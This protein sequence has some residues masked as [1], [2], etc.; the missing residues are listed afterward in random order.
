MEK[1]HIKKEEQLRAITESIPGIVFQF[2]A[3]DTGEFGVSH[4]SGG[5]FGLFGLQAAGDDLF[6]AIASCAHED[7]RERFIASVRRSVET[8]TA[9][10]YEGRFVR[11]DGGVRWF[12]GRSAPTRLTDRVVFNGI[13][14]DVTENKLAEERS[15]QSEEK[16][17]KV[18]MMAPDPICITRMEDGQIVDVNLGFEEATG[19]KRN[20]VIGRTTLEIGLWA[21]AGDRLLIM[22]ELKARKHVS[23]RELQFRLKDGSLHTGVYSARFIHI[24]G[25]LHLISVI[26]DVTE[27][28][29]IAKALQESQERLQGIAMNIP[30]SVF[31]TYR[32]GN[33]ELGLSYMNESLRELLGIPPEKSGSLEDFLSYVHEDDRKRF[34]DSVGKALTTVTPWEFEGRFV[35]R[36]GEAVWLHGRAS[37]A[38]VE[39]RLVFN[40][41]FIDVTESKRAEQEQEKLREQ[42]SQAHKMES[43]GRL[44]GGVAHDFNNMLTV[45]LGHAEMAMMQCDPSDRLYASLK[46]IQGSALHSTSL[47]QQLLAFARKQT[48]TP[49]TLDLNDTVA[50]MVEMLR[51]LIGEDIDFV[52]KPGASLWPVKIDPSQ[53]DQLL[54]N[55]CVNSRDA[56]T[57]VGRI[58]VET[59]NT[60]FGDAS[61]NSHPGT[62]PGEYVMLAVSDNGCGM[63]KET[64]DQIFEPFFT[65]KETGKGTGLGLAT[66]YGIAQQNGGFVNVYS[67]PGRGSTFKAY[68]PRF[69]G[70]AATI[71]REATAE[72]PRGNGETVLLVEDVKVV[73]VLGR[74]M[75]ERLGY[76]VIAAAT[77]GE[78]IQAAKE[79]GTE[80]DLLIT[81]VIMPE[82]NGRDLANLLAGMIP[83]LKCLFVSGYT[84]DAITHQG[85]LEEGVSFLEKPFSVKSLAGK[86][87]EVLQQG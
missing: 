28:R 47:V 73:L 57:G 72:P 83:G 41:I 58:T 71:A 33:G 18:F 9:W 30:G 82:M 25:E 69:H 14:L 48:V 16:F 26:Q 27:H 1:S 46:A 75:L 79:R 6:S 76:T 66:V 54:T 20:E 15:R 43:I 7:D 36:T 60:T 3:L 80:I 44:A 11:L 2:Y 37:P 59:R 55:L 87:R 81:D 77:P 68:L 85:I 31:Q 8:C 35:T 5:P 10:D 70:E 65:T 52:W 51:R 39:D 29:K 61:G 49:R 22:E 12:H 74:A 53:V 32:K 40:G 56:I 45:I 17:A 19:W 78:A 38:R 4:I 64:A 42:L 84:A 86:V 62:V 50:S 63:D 34:A 23:Q 67:E 13:L 24:A 21:D